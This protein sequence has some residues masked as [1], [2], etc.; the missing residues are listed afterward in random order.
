[1]DRIDWNKKRTSPPHDLEWLGK[2]FPAA[3]KEY[4]INNADAGPWSLGPF[5]L[6]PD[7]VPYFEGD[8]DDY[9]WSERLGAWY[10]RSWDVE[11]NPEWRNKYK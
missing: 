2:N 5:Y 8:D 10:P 11:N 7:G 6:T 9:V 3:A 1:M 4:S